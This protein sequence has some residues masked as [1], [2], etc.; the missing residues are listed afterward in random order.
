MSF[1]KLKTARDMTIGKS[2]PRPSW[3]SLRSW[4]CRF[5]QV[6]N[7]VRVRLLAMRTAEEFVMALL[8]MALLFVNLDATWTAIEDV[9]GLLFLLATKFL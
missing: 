6:L 4:L 7:V 9:S 1:C 8:M 3:S 2:A 5:A